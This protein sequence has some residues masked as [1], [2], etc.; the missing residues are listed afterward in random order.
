[1]H[2]FILNVEKVV[3]LVAILK[4]YYE[5]CTLLSPMKNYK[6]KIPLQ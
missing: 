3:L 2:I 5:I 6:Q 4:K 1:M